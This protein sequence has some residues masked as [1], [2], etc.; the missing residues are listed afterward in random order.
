MQLSSGSVSDLAQSSAK[1]PSELLVE[2]SAEGSVER[3][4]ESSAESAGS[5]VASLVVVPASATATLP[6]DLIAVGHI[7]GSYGI[8]GWVRIHPYSVQA[9]ALLHAKTW[10]LATSEFS[11]VQSDAK[12]HSQPRSKQSQKMALI[13]PS[14]LRDVEKLEAKRHGED[15]V[16]RLIGVVGRDAAQALKGTVVHIPRS[17][18]PALP[19]GEF[20]WLDL[21]G[22]AVEN[23]EGEYLGQVADLI[24]NGAHPILRVVRATPEPLRE[25]LIPF[26]TR[27][28]PTVDLKS[29]KITVDWGLDY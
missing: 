10:W 6:T 17:H 13:L 28:V 2:N 11:A 27:F 19:E 16:A 26:V 14:Q 18:F 12:T 21:I 25:Y 8:Q 5:V 24:D 7:T 9:D 20:Y 22:L 15:V 1:S 29:K 4:A 3:L 23:G